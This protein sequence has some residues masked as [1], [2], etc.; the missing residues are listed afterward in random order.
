M[1]RRRAQSNF[2]K[3]TLVGTSMSLYYVHRA[4][5]KIDDRISFRGRHINKVLVSFHATNFD[6]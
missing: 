1:R 4:R 2:L 3:H 6:K 5:L